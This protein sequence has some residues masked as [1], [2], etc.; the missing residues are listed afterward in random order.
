VKR[1][2]TLNAIAGTFRVSGSAI[3]A[4][5]HLTNPDRLREGQ[6]LIIPPKPPLRLTATPGEGQQGDAFRIN[7]QG[8]APSET[9]TFEI[10]SPK[11]KY[12]GAPHA[13]LPDGTV[14]AT[15]QT[16]LTDATG[17]YTV[18]ARGNKG[19]TARTRFTLVSAAITPPT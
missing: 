14:T 10:D 19:T 9:V 4:R 8:A 15:Y 11:A 1:G 3:L 13:A 6:V 12:T 18:I 16:A 17:T 2:D 7:L 5:N